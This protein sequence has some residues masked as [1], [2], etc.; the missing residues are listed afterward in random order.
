MCLGALSGAGDP[1]RGEIAD[2][3][4]RLSYQLRRRLSVK[5]EAMIPGGACDIRRT[6]EAQRRYERALP[7]LPRGYKAKALEEAELAEVS[8]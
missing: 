8:A 7:W 6:E 4:G 2:E 5:E 1:R 3:R